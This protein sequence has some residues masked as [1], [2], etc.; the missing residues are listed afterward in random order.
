MPRFILAFILIGDLLEIVEILE[1]Y[2]S[3]L[4]ARR[5]HPKENYHSNGVP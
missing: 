2:N 1:M 4:E 3:W 5:T